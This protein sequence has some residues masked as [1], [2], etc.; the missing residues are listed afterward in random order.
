MR[1]RFAH[2]TVLVMAA[3]AGCAEPHNDPTSTDE[4]PS[5]DIGRGWGSSEDAWIRPGV[6]IE[7]VSFA[8]FLPQRGRCTAN[9]I[10]ENA[11]SQALYVGTAAHCFENDPLGR[12]VT[13]G[14][15]GRTINATL[16]YS[17]WNTMNLT[18]AQAQE[19]CNREDA[20]FLDDRICFND[21]ALLEIAKADWGRVH[22]SM[23]VYGGPTGLG[24]TPM[25]GSLVST[26]GSS[27]YRPVTSETTDARSGP[28]LD[29]NEKRILIHTGI[30][31]TPGDSGSPVVD[32]DL[33]AVGV[34]I[35]LYNL[36]PTTNGAADLAWLLDEAS[37]AGHDVALV[38]A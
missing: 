33:R 27:Q 34:L 29:A 24:P 31:S 14:Y 18:M 17:S 13:L 4:P 15:A 16:A 37:R 9:F 3:F 35:H 36:P 7:E 26:Y 11:S 21:F 5:A 22:P 12:P 1:L 38:L 10:Y 2:F 6:P 32:A 20:I 30:P 19:A 8:S 25:A 28:V 23:L